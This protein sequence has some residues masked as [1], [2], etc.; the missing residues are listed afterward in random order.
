V[1]LPPSKKIFLGGS[2]AI[3]GVVFQFVLA[4]LYSH[5][6]EAV[7]SGRAADPGEVDRKLEVLREQMGLGFNGVTGSWLFLIFGLLLLMTGVYQNAKATE[8]LEARL[9]PAGPSR[10]NSGGAA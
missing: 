10:E 7:M 4:Y 9:N 1:I 5:S 6:M 2:A 3:S 8:R